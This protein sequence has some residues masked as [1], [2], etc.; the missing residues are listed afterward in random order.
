MEN[1]L[2]QAVNAMLQEYYWLEDPIESRNQCINASVAFLNF[3]GISNEDHHLYMRCSIING[4][5]HYYV[6]IEG[7][8]FDFTASQYGLPFPLIK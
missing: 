8:T 2:N 7:K 1:K 4:E 6:E 3:L 5:E